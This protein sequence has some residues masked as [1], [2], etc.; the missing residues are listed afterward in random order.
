MKEP[1]KFPEKPQ[2]SG[3]EKSEKILAEI[4]KTLDLKNQYQR[5]VEMLKDVG[6]LKRLSTGKFGINGIDK[7]EYPLPDYQEIKTRIKEKA[8]VLKQKIDQ[9]FSKLLLVPFGMSLDRLIERYQEVLWK[10]YEQK[11]LF[12]PIQNTENEPTFPDNLPFNQ[13]TIEAIKNGSKRYED[14][15]Q[16]KGSVYDKENS[17]L[18][19]VE[20]YQNADV[21]EILIYH[22]QQFL[23]YEH[24]GKTKEEILKEGKNG[25]YILLVEDLPSIPQK[26]QGKILGGRKQIETGISPVE[27]LKKLKNKEYEQE[28]GMTIEEYIIYAISY[29]EEKNQVIDYYYIDS[30]HNYYGAQA[31]LIG[32][33]VNIFDWVPCGLFLGNFC[34]S[35]LSWSRPDVAMSHLGIR[36]VVRI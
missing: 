22:P 16:K 24:K 5:Q 13:E 18:F 35:V 33:Y 6:I 10:H 29:L 31:L 36:T 27:C 19:V 9:G 34:W 23:K 21:N 28:S 3:K 7:K 14:I 15:W 12:V 32:N 30:S 26:N 11:K 2:E 8:E 25:F 17:A 20:N 1:E 4:E